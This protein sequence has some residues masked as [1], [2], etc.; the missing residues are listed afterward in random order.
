MRNFL[1]AL[2]VVVVILALVG[3]IIVVW[4]D[5]QPENKPNGDPKNP[6][7]LPNQT[8]QYTPIQLRYNYQPGDHLVYK[9]NYFSTG[10]ITKKDKLPTESVSEEAFRMKIAGKLHQYI[11]EI[12]DKKIFAGYILQASKIEIS[13]DDNKLL[14]EMYKVLETEIFVWFENQGA[15]ERWFFPSEIPADLRNTM[16][17]LLLNA[18]VHFADEAKKDWQVEETDMNGKYQANYSCGFTAAA[19]RLVISKSKAKYLPGED[20]MLPT[21]L[22]SKGTIQW[23]PQNQVIQ[24]LDW[25][26]SLEMNALDFNT[27]G[28]YVITLQLESKVN[29]PNLA[30]TMD[31]KITKGKVYETKSHKTEGQEIMKR[32]NL[33]RL[34]GNRT[35][36]DIR[37]AIQQVRLDPYNAQQRHECYRVLGAWM[38]LHPE[39]IPDITKLVIDTKDVDAMVSTILSALSDVENPAGQ[40]AFKEIIEKRQDDPKMVSMALTCM[41][42]MPNPTDSSLELAQNLHRSN[43]N[44]QVKSSSALALGG[45][46]GQ[47]R[48]KDPARANALIYDMEQNLQTAQNTEQKKLYLETLGNAGSSSSLRTITPLLDDADENVRVAAASSLRFIDSPEADTLLAQ[49]FEKNTS[50]NIRNSI[51]D[52]LVYRKPTQT[53]FAAIQKDIDKDPSENLRVKRARA[54]WQMRHQFPLGETTVRNMLA[55]DPSSKVRASLAQMMLVDRDQ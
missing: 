13:A 52:T 3:I 43:E 30:S 27:V 50:F 53:M 2:G 41:V 29:D 32:R 26:E 49:S 12:K 36:D 33:E 38:E 31:K 46:I 8:T 24:K 7:P 19:D 54:L 45:M 23:D 22:K 4:P 14:R 18:Q 48:K 44:Q 16:K 37:H 21:I 42:M 39:T 15:I 9:V 6:K 11:Y 5:N 17:S 35:M 25:E 10:K 51:L 20:E 55:N 47:I 28:T 1:I 34:V 40:A